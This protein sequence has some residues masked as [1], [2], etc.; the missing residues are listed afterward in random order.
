M[1]ACEISVPWVFRRHRHICPGCGNEW[2]LGNAMR[3][4]A[5]IPFE[6]L[7]VHVIAVQ[8]V[9]RV[10]VLSTESASQSWSYSSLGPTGAESLAQFHYTSSPQI[11]FNLA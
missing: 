9:R 4:F 2:A 11:S 6:H 3:L 7:S 10:E 5:H 1:G 8:A